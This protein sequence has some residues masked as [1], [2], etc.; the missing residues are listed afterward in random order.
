[1]F[2]RFEGQSPGLHGPVDRVYGYLEGFPAFDLF[3][4]PAFF[5]PSSENGLQLFVLQFEG[6]PAAF[7]AQAIELVCLKNGHSIPTQSDSRVTFSLDIDKEL[8][9]RLTIKL[10]KIIVFCDCNA[11]AALDCEEDEFQGAGSA[12]RMMGRQWKGGEFFNI[13]QI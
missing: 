12:L 6:R 9:G 5:E 10:I 13:V 4:R 2:P 11:N 3:R 1:M 8:C 7:A